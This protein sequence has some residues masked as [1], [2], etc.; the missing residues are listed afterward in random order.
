VRRETSRAI[1]RAGLKGMS[2]LCHTRSAVSGS[3]M[4][5]YLLKYKNRPLSFEKNIKSKYK[6][7]TPRNRSIDDIHLL[8]RR[9]MNEQFKSIFS[10][11]DL[12]FSQQ[13]L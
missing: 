7:N 3:P 1:H 2:R 10:M 9:M 4:N 12:R 8:K 13:I 11:S 5:M 6:Y